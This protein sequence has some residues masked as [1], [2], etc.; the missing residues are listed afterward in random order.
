MGFKGIFSGI[1]LELM[2]SLCGIQWDCYWYLMDYLV[3]LWEFKEISN[4]NDTGE[5]DQFN[6]MLWMIWVCPDMMIN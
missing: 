4:L 5:T 2:G 1:S 3:S 6:K